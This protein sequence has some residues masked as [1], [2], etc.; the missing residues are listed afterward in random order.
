MHEHKTKKKIS[1]IGRF[2]RQSKQLFLGNGLD[3]AIR[4]WIRYTKQSK[5]TVHN[6]ITQHAS[7][8]INGAAHELSRASHANP[9][10][11][12]ECSIP[13]PMPLIE[14]SH[15]LQPLA[16]WT[17]LRAPIP[18]RKSLLLVLTLRTVCVTTHRG[19]CV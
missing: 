11:H 1:I 10:L 14:W 17:C 5:P 12:A 9:E 2:Q 7:A 3:M 18:L 16:L 6:I 13:H 19:F 4:S 15:H 8:L